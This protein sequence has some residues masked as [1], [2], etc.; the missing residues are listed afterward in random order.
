MSLQNWGFGPFFQAQTPPQG[1][2]ARVVAQERGRWRLI[3]AEGE[4]TAQA[5]GLL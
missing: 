3:T 1:L 4:R 5:R 2:P